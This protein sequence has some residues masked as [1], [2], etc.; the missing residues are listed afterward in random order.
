MF[1]GDSHN[2]LLRDGKTVNTIT[3]S[4]QHR[5]QNSN[6]A[7][8]KVQFIQRLV[9]TDNKTQRT[10]HKQVLILIQMKTR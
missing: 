6:N 1:Q 5:Y 9:L 8:P 7:P 3:K 10:Q 4:S 2:L